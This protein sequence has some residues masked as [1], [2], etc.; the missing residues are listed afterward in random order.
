MCEC[1]DLEQRQVRVTAPDVGG[2]FGLEFV[3]GDAGEPG[4]DAAVMAGGDASDVG[5]GEAGAEGGFE[6][7]EAGVIEEIR[8]VDDDELGFF[9]LLGV[10]VEDFGGEAGAGG[11]AEDAF[12][13]DGIDEDELGQPLFERK[14]RGI[15]LTEFGRY[16]ATKAAGILEHVETVLADTKRWPA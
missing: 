14:G 9:E 10:D 7:I 5:L 15:V 13:A 6:A 3:A 4:V 1:L 12:G 2:G 8:F 16:F 11:E